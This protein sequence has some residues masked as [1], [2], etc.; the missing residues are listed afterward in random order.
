MSPNCNGTDG[1]ICQ[2]ETACF[3]VTR[4]FEHSKESLRQYRSGILVDA[5]QQNL[6]LDVG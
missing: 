3:L 5:E 4:K 6:L 2:N 1:D